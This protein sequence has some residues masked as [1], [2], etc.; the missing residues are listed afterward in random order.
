MIKKNSIKLLILE[1][2]FFL[3]E[4]D[5]LMLGNKFLIQEKSFSL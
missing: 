3:L 4:H 1:T 2:H 5:F